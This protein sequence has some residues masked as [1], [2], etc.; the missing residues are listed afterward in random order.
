[1]SW[2]LKVHYP[3]HKS[4]SSPGLCV[5]FCN[6]LIV[7]T[8]A[9]LLPPDPPSRC[10]VQ[11]SHISICNMRMHHAMMCCSWLCLHFI[12]LHHLAVIQHNEI[13][14]CPY[15]RVSG[16]GILAAGDNDFFMISRIMSHYS[17]IGHI[18]THFQKGKPMLRALAASV[19]C[20]EAQ[21]RA[22]FPHFPCSVVLSHLL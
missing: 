6:M 17:K 3:M 18:Y 21:F 10:P 11:Y 5:R 22:E 4:L 14:K 1:M 13:A 15:W 19:W 2:K 7:Y 12:Y 20:Y 16:I 8:Q 9:F